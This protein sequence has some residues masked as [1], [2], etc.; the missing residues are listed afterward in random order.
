MDR[1]GKERLVETLRATFEGAG[2]VVVA[3]YQGIAA[4]EATRLR[5]AMRAAGASFRVTKNSLAK[6]AVEGTPYAHMAELFAGPTAIAWSDDD[7]VAAARATVA[8]AKDNPYIVVLGGGLRATALD[9]AAVRNLASLPS[10]DEL[11]ARLVGVI[12][13]PATR[14]AGALQ[15]PAGQLARVFKAHADARA[16]AA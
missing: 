11:R 5:R 15:A 13:A 2:A 12:N 9:E 7:P 10:L 14:V 3:H 1:A 4:A 6:R 8:A 16:E